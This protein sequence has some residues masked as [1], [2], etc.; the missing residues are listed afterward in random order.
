MDQLPLPSSCRPPPTFR[1]PSVD[2]KACAAPPSRLLTWLATTTCGHCAAVGPPLSATEFRLES[3]PELKYDA[4]GATPKVRRVVVAAL[5]G[6]GC[7]S[8]EEAGKACPGE[9]GPLCAPVR[10]FVAVQPAFRSPCQRAAP[11]SKQLLAL[12]ASLPIPRERS[13]SAAPCC[14]RGIT[15]TRSAPRPRSMRRASST[16]VS[17]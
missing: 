3:V 12:L 5:W 11:G 7:G 6:R 1:P 4:S 14:L 16:Q 8:A 13:A 9:L 17:G 10:L 2:W 15:R